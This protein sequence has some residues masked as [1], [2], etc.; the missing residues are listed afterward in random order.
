[1]VKVVKPSVR[2]EFLGLQH[3]MKY[4]LIRVLSKATRSVNSRNDKRK[5]VENSF[6]PLLTWQDVVRR[7]LEEAKF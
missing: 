5:L 6:K 7:Y 3:S 4:I 1:M 2:G